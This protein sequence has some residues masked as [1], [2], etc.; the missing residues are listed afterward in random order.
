M[1]SLL[2][3]VRN[4]FLEPTFDD[5][6]DVF[7][8]FMSDTPSQLFENKFKVD[9]QNNE[10]E[11][12]IDSEFPG[13][14]K[15]DIKITIENDHLVIGCEHKEEKEDKDKN[16]I[17]KERSYSSMQRRFYLPNADEENITAELKDGVLNIVVPKVEESSKQKHIS[18]K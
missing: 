14:S 1:R 17:H 9:L 10:K 12:V 6:Y 4:G 3:R 7:D 18:I 16:Y 5:M 2:P 13:Y 11:Y 15:E 8:R